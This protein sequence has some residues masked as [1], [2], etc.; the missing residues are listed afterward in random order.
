MQANPRHVKTLFLF[1]K[2]KKNVGM[3]GCG[4]S[5]ERERKRARGS[6]QSVLQAGAKRWEWGLCV[7]AEVAEVHAK[8]GSCRFRPYTRA[9]KAYSLHILA[10]E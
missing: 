10:A 8:A 9:G 4:F 6:V 2:N 5:G 7:M 1:L 3:G